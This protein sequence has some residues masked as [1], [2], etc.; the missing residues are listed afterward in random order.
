MANLK[1][2]IKFI[3]Y[4]SLTQKIFELFKR[5]EKIQT[6]GGQKAIDKQ[7]SMGKLTAR[8]RI[9]TLLAQIPFMNMIYL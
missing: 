2:R 5:K 9:K 8:E 1:I 7:A 4:M 3:S 6:G